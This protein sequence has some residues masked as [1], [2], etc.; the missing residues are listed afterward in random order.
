MTTPP[1]SFHIAAGLSG[2]L[3]RA[4]SLSTPH[5]VIETPAFVS[6]GTKATIKALTPEQLEE[7]GVSIILGNT[8]HLYLQPGDDVV[9]LAG[10][11]GKFMNWKG[12]TMTDSGGFQVFSLG[13]AFGTGASKFAFDMP[14]E[15]AITVY[16]RHFSLEQA[17]LARIDE[18]GVTFTSHLDGSTHRLT[19]E[20]S[21]EIQHN[22]GADIIFAF[23]ECT[24]PAAP[25]KY[26]KEAMDRTHR[27]ADRSL[28]AHRQNI[29]V[30]RRQ[31]LFGI[32]QGGRFQDLRAGSA[33]YLA[34]MPFDGYGIGGSF[35]KI[36]LDA[37]LELV[38][39]ILPGD[40]P[41]HLLGIGE[42]EDLFNGI[43]KG[44]DTF[45]CVVPTRIARTGMLYTKNGKINILNKKYIR[46][47]SPITEGCE[48]LVCKSY[49][50][51]Y[52]AH[53]FRAREMLGATLASYHN[54][55]FIVH[56]VKEIRQS[57]LDGRF[58]DFKVIFLQKYED[59]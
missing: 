55:Y 10:G 40:R 12:P 19:P 51:A 47:I 27:W 34:E 21:I 28:K 31:A 8:Y 44:I 46:D 13:D 43:E 53:L 16:D 17:R 30:G 4:G 5:G 59:N 7:M 57:I 38:N 1:L 56:L 2:G 22:L 39:S 29:E 24:S 50:K 14:Q 52:L 36:D 41:R 26:Q 11:I 48:C 18:E 42:P 25:K 58:E 54:L 9:A 15:D 49:T 37:S 20:R 35:S 45:D 32:V 3:G 33:Q 6:V 23:D